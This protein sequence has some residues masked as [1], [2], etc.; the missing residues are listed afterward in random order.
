MFPTSNLW[1]KETK[2]Q[3][4]EKGHRN[5]LSCESQ[6]SRERNCSATSER[7]RRHHFAFRIDSRF[8]KRDGKRTLESS[9]S[10]AGLQASADLGP[11][12]VDVL[13]DAKVKHL[14]RTGAFPVVLLRLWETREPLSFPSLLPS[15][16]F[17]PT[18]LFGISRS[19]RVIRAS[20]LVERASQFQID[21]L[22]SI[23]LSV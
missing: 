21:V 18:G 23:P 17:P 5:C 20:S 3:P 6:P 4:F 14:S 22:T 9:G 19:P 8:S 2:V 10:P 16:P 11:N 7:P 13:Y 12:V 15:F 1:R